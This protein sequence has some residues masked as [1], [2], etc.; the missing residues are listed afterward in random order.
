MK[1][2]GVLFTAVLFLILILLG[3][4][5]LIGGSVSLGFDE[6]FST[7]G[8]LLRPGENTPIS[9]TLAIL[10][11]RL[12]RYLLAAMVGIILGASGAVFQGLFMNPLADPYVVGTSSG[13][14]LGAVVAITLGGFSF[15]S[16]SMEGISWFGLSGIS[17]MAFA[18]GLGATLLVYLIAGFFPRSSNSTTVL[19]AGSA[20][21]SFFS[22]SISILLTLKDR[23]LHRAF[24]WLLGGFSGRSWAH[25]G[26]L[27][28]P[29]C[30]SLFIGMVGARPLDILSGGD[31]QAQ[32]L[33][34]RPSVTRLLLSI[35]MAIGISAAV[36]VA[37]TIGFV[38]LVSPHIARRVVGPKHRIVI[39]SAA[40]VGAIMLVVAD[41]GARTLVPPIELPV[42]ALTALIGAPYFL[43][44]LL[45]RTTA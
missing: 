1:K 39:P 44:K 24:F 8:K 41:I 19:L 9:P 30:L 34:L 18:G 37:G 40:L 22:A 20:M 16:P 17:L 2:T 31:E 27:I 29:T 45:K 11:L 10:R 43:V 35:G 21:G 33:G 5:A 25:L 36:S 26:F 28:W 14:A 7:L 15:F 13:A 6:V 42:G 23:D 38:G 3:P 4:L 32:S 12:L